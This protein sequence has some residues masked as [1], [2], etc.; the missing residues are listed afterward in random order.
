[1][2][3]AVVRTCALCECA[4]HAWWH[5]VAWHPYPAQL[6][7]GY[8][9]ALT[10]GQTYDVRDYLNEERRAE[11]SRDVHTGEVGFVV[12]DGTWVEVLEVMCGVE[13]ESK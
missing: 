11:C 4:S 3:V 5:T 7:P 13:E 12:G 9:L 8:R 1:M 2:N 10:V 6:A